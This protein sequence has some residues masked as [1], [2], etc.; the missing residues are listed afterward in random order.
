MPVTVQLQDLAA[1]LSLLQARTKLS[2]WHQQ[3]IVN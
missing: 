2:I 3:W 1:M